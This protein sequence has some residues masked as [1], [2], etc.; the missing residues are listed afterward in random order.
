MGIDREDEGIEQ[1]AC[2]DHCLDLTALSCA[3]RQLL[4]SRSGAGKLRLSRDRVQEWRR[5]NA[6]SFAGMERKGQKI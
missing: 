1:V 6:H 2:R 3:A 5:R 4:R